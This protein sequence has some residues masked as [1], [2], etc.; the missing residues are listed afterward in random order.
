[1]LR[2]CIDFQ[3]LNANTVTNSWPLSQ[4]YEFLACLKGA[5]FLSKLDLRDGFHQ[6][7]LAG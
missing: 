2:L 4:I 6:I 1:M 5:R 7:L 3:S